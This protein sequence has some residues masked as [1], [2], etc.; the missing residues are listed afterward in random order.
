[1]STRFTFTLLYI[2]IGFALS[3]FFM[4][5]TDVKIFDT[6]CLPSINIVVRD[7]FIKFLSDDF[8]LFGHLFPPTDWLASISAQISLLAL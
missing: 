2:F 4:G 6:A 3:R 8:Q 1:M 7:L 5:T